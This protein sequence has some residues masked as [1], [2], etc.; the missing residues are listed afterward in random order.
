MTKAFLRA[1]LLGIFF[2]SA[3]ILTGTPSA[4]ALNFQDEIDNALKSGALKAGQS[5]ALKTLF[6]GASK[7]PGLNVSNVKASN[8][9]ITGDVNFLKS[10]WNLLAYSSGG[11]KST[12]IAF[13]PKRIFKF[14]DIFKKIP[15]IELLDTIKFDDQLLTFA[16]GDVEV[17]SKDLPANVRAITDKFFETSTYTLAIP[18]GLTNFATFNLGN[19]KPLNDAIKFLGGKSA[20]IFTTVSIIGNVL[21]NLLAGQ[22]PVPQIVMRAA[23]PTFRPS[24]G[25]KITLPANVQFA[26]LATLTPSEIKAAQSPTKEVI[27]K[28]VELGLEGETVFRVGKQDVN[29]VLE[30]GIKQTTGAPEISVTASVF[31]GL[32]WK[33][34]FGIKWLTIEDYRMTF[35]QEADS[36]KV[37]FGGKT[38]I[39]SKRL[40]AFALAAVSAKTIGIPIPERINLAIDD[41]PDKVGSIGIRDIASIYLE[42]IKA[43]SGK[44]LK[45][46]KEFPDV[47]IA[48]TEKGKGPSIALTL[49][50]S[51]ETGIDMSGALRILGSNLA[52]V[53]RAFVQADEG[54]EIRAKTAKLGVGP[55]KF[56]T[57]DVEVMLRAS[58]ADREIPQPRILIKATGMSLFGSKSEMDLAMRLNQFQLRALQNFGSLFKFNFLATT[59]EPIESLEH[60]A[61]AD[62]H[63]ASSLSSDPGGWLRTSG[64]KAVEVAFA[65]IRKDVDAATADLKK[66]QAEVAKLDN[67]I[68]KMKA[69][70]AKEREA[71]A[72]Q[73]KA[74]E[75]EVNKLNRQISDL[76]GKINAKKGQIHSCNQSKRI[77]VLSKPKKT[78][79]K[80][81]ILGKCVIPKISMECV[82][83]VTVADLPARAVCQAKNVKPAAELA[84]FETAKGTLIASREV[85][86]KTLEGLRKGITNIPVE[87]DPRVSGLIVARETAM[88]TLKAAEATVK[89]FGEFT[90]ILTQGVNVVGKP[91]IFALEKSSI[92][93]SMR[94]A[95]TGK[96]VVLT[97]NFRMLGKPYHN[98][99]AFSLTDMGFNAKQLEVLALGA[100]TKTVL[101]AGYKAKIVPHVLL[102]KVNAIY[103]KK[104]AEV[105]AELDKA[106]AANHVGT[107]E[108]MQLAGVGATVD[109]Y[110]TAIKKK[111]DAVK[112]A[113]RIVRQK[114][115][116]LAKLKKLA[117]LQ[118]AALRAVCLK[119]HNNK[120][121]VAAENDKKTVNANRPHCKSYERFRIID[122]N[123]KKDG[124]LNH[125]D[126]IHIRTHHGRYW[127]AQPNG[128]LE[129]NRTQAKTW[130]TF[131]IYKIV[132][133]KGPAIQ[134]GD[135]VAFYTAHKRWVVAEGGGGNVMNANRKDRKTW[136]IFTFLPVVID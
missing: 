124:G 36:V 130:E 14:Q 100:A 52:T 82:K 22:P 98:R 24:I 56:P 134:A 43:A 59:G 109:A 110:N 53:D 76:Q 85:A 73:L 3:G 119:A 29:M 6:R 38:S 115:R 84:A 55:F 51:G 71:P 62:F 125:G 33:R 87:L 7:L 118:V 116:R 10:N 1:I 39:G 35:G 65:Q 30:T 107:N 68:A 113:N 50:A 45:M 78:G 28:G 105:N 114:N 5:S 12:F 41:G 104:R 17:E 96:P 69:Q 132:G 77:C 16:M 94:G 64:K 106:L 127:S 86:S 111:T 101:D 13:G 135:K 93:G 9:A 47:S 19:A 32:P 91:D 75:D 126:Y 108:K 67:E 89:G 90:K 15:G 136:E 49:K 70:V 80:K 122:I 2:V 61:D 123:A 102:D 117:S 42:M 25:G 44:K 4:Q 112:Q 54:I 66:A 21:D 40:D 37:G 83:H 79:C 121:Y 31:K 88:G 95:I 20:K 57:A 46:P 34:A 63:L 72:K 133:S 129:A 8:G 120:H 26:L 23:L 131:R 48:G 27:S 103:T 99:F 74:A 18:Q 81:K 97:M 11:A 128:K 60:L 58:A 92:N